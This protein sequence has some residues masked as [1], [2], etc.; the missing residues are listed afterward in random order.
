MVFHEEVEEPVEAEKF[1]SFEEMEFPRSERLG[2]SPDRQT[3]YSMDSQYNDSDS[4]SDYEQVGL[5]AQEWDPS[6]FRMRDCERNRRNNLIA[7][8]E[9]RETPWYG[10]V[11]RA[12]ATRVVTRSF[13][14]EADLPEFGLVLNGTPPETKIDR[15]SIKAEEKALSP[16]RDLERTHQLLTELV[17]KKII[18]ESQLA[19]FDAMQPIHDELTMEQGMHAMAMKPVFKD[20]ENKKPWGYDD[21]KMTFLKDGTLDVTQM[22]L[23]TSLYDPDYSREDEDISYDSMPSL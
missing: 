6:P 9:E 3:V 17:A 20:I 4:W 8:E 5:M 18:S 1:K 12:N 22:Y 7:E 13:Q 16:I 15:S 21:F 2:V 14:F 10:Q 23:D 11:H 19:Q